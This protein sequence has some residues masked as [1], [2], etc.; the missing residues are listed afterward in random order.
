MR[1]PPD[2]V[3]TDES[4]FIATQ[5]PIFEDLIEVNASLAATD[6]HAKFVAD[7]PLFFPWDRPR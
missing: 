5:A 3:S 7:S 1:E 6:T 4:S 2:P